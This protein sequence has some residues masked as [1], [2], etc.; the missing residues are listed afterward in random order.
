M[1]K[2]IEKENKITSKMRVDQLKILDIYAEE[3]IE[4]DT[5][6]QFL[7]NISTKLNKILLDLNTKENK[8]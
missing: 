2:E 7:I 1:S 8:K 3:A 5:L 4:D 6:K